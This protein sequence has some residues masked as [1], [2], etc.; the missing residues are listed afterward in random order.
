MKEVKY[1]RFTCG[2]IAIIVIIV[3]ACYI[4]SCNEDIKNILGNILAGLITWEAIAIL[5][6][7]KNKYLYEN[8]KKIKQ[9]Q[10]QINK[11]QEIILTQIN[12]QTKA[13][14]TIVE[15][16]GLYTEIYN[17]LK[18]YYEIKDINIKKSI[19]KLNKDWKEIDKEITRKIQDLSKKIMQENSISL[20]NY[21]KVYQRN[22]ANF[23]WNIHSL[24]ESLKKD[25]DYIIDDTEKL[26]KSVI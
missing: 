22:L 2:V 9:Y 11:S 3:L 23:I 7:L 4:N 10:E 21:K 15:L 16:I 6:N 20:N 17:N 14:I 25:I 24:Q 12:L 8:T 26:S 19:S 5:S 18:I 1:Y 13:Q